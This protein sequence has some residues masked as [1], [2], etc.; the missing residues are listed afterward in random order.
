M[1]WWIGAAL[2]ADICPPTGDL[3]V[4]LVKSP[5][6]TSSASQTVEQTLKGLILDSDDGSCRMA[7]TWRKVDGDPN[8]YVAGRVKHRVRQGDWRG[9]QGRA[10]QKWVDQNL[11]EYAT[12]SPDDEGHDVVVSVV[13]TGDQVC[14]RR[15][16]LGQRGAPTVRTECVDWDA[17]PSAYRKAARAIFPEAQLPTYYVTISQTV[18]WLTTPTH[19]MIEC[20]PGTACLEQVR[21]L[22]H[23][24]VEL[25]VAGSEESTAMI[26]E[27][28]VVDCEER[29]QVLWTS[30]KAQGAFPLREVDLDK[31]KVCVEVTPDAVS[32]R[33][34]TIE[35]TLDEPEELEVANDPDTKWPPSIYWIGDDLESTWS[36]S[37]LLGRN[38]GGKCFGYHDDEEPDALVTLAIPS[39]PKDLGAAE[40]L[41]SRV[42]YV[43]EQ[44]PDGK[45]G[46]LECDD[47]TVADHATGQ[48]SAPLT[49]TTSNKGPRL[50]F[51]V[52]DQVPGETRL[53]VQMPGSYTFSAVRI[54]DDGPPSA[55]QSIQVFAVYSRMSIYESGWETSLGGGLQFYDRS[56]SV[57]ANAGCGP[58]TLRPEIGAGFVFEEH[59]VG[60]WG[61]ADRLVMQGGITVNA[62]D[63]WASR[64]MFGVLGRLTWER[65]P[66]PVYVAYAA[67]PELDLGL[68]ITTNTMVWSDTADS[69]VTPW[70]AGEPVVSHMDARLGIRVTT[71]PGAVRMGTMLVFSPT[72]VPWKVGGRDPQVGLY[73][74]GLYVGANQKPS[75]WRFPRTTETMAPLGRPPPEDGL[76][77]AMAT[78]P[79]INGE[80]KE[81]DMDFAQRR[82]NR[83]KL[84]GLRR[85]RRVYDRPWVDA[86]PIERDYS[87]YDCLP[88]PEDDA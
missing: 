63:L 16:D 66:R 72:G 36:R 28:R 87:P 4:T 34:L 32:S 23:H 81:T 73:V 52:S 77:I 18:P 80:D 1:L 74:E 68:R 37:G 13:P 84:R 55:E 35:V 69:Y 65:E 25:S 42:R 43:L 39:P 76:E 41:N 75:A 54:Q 70:N 48:V 14:L 22:V 57:V 59:Y 15:F 88:D 31:D 79:V 46:Q 78:C 17:G 49:C 30:P 26:A 19:Q 12:A 83:Q 10:L 56:T 67:R 85:Q 20:E 5:D 40:R 8:S 82:A 6:I 61:P 33:K 62:I 7:T 9:A 60:S 27:W 29:T 24:P 47:I 53:H 3:Q 51:E 11:P 21:A 64:H 50:V 45:R 38:W 2:A 44:A 58:V 86:D 71:G